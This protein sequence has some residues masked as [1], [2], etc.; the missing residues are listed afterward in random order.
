[1]PSPPSLHPGWSDAHQVAIAPS[2]CLAPI[3]HG[4]SVAR[5]YAALEE[6]RGMDD[7][8]VTFK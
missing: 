1:M 6:K 2:D 4:L 5:F 3:A 8:Y 7:A